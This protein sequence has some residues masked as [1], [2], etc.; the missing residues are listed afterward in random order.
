VPS[1]NFIILVARSTIER[2][3]LLSF[4]QFWDSNVELNKLFKKLVPKSS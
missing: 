2:I 4:V 1:D 3:L